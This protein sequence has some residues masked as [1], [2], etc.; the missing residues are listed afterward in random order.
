M[1]NVQSHGRQKPAL[2]RMVFFLPSHSSY[3]LLKPE[4]ADIRSPTQEYIYLTIMLF[5]F[6]RTH[7]TLL[8]EC[9]SAKVFS[10]LYPVISRDETFFSSL[11]GRDHQIYQRK[12][13]NYPEVPAAA[14]SSGILH[15]WACQLWAAETT[16]RREGETLSE[17][18]NG[19][20]S[21]SL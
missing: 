17:G 16:L 5:F 18:D 12:W 19:N 14:S 2:T 7:V 8:C 13:E 9:P 3:Y 1:V 6:P 15:I 11:P 21:I 10:D 4:T 20:N